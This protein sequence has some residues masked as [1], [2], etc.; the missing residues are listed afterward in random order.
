MKNLAGVKEADLSIKEELYL[1]GIEAVTGEAKGEVPYTLEGRIGKWR[2]RRAWYYWVA[3]VEIKT[4]GL[5]LEHALELHNMPNPIDSDK[6]MGTSIR[7]G[8]HCGCPSPDEYGAQPVYDESLNKKL[9][10]LGY[11]TKEFQG[12]EYVSINVGEMSELC[13]SGKLDVKQ[14]VDCYHIDDQIGLNEFAKYLRALYN[15][16]M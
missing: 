15:L 2:L 1:A 3:S 13:K 10:A 5:E 16:D 4:D 6:I 12:K 8:G 7:S 11:E 9:V 14:Y